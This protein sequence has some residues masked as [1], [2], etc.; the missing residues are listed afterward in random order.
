MHRVSA[1]E[2]LA[3]IGKRYNVQPANIVAVN[4]LD[5]EQPQ[6]GD[7]LLIP[8]LRIEAPVRKTPAATPARRRPAAATATTTHRR[9]VTTSTARPAVRKPAAIVAR[10]TN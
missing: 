7:R 3:V 9:P 2:T 10:N 1:G 6:E 8:A 4:H 5:S